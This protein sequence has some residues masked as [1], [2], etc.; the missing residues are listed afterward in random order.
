ML[1]LIVYD[2]RAFRDHLFEQ[3]AQLRNV[4]PVAQ[5]EVLPDCLVTVDVESRKNAR[6]A[7]PTHMFRSAQVEDQGPCR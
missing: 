6:L 7:D 2:R 1:D 3:T 4:P 5:L